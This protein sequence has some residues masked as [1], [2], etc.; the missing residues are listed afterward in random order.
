MAEVAGEVPDEV[1]QGQRHEQSPHPLA[2]ERVGLTRRGPRGGEDRRRIDL[3]ARQLGGE[4][5]RGAPE[6]GTSTTVR[7]PL[8]S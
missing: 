2:Y 3:L 6:R 1:P 8:V 4:V 7:F 5:E